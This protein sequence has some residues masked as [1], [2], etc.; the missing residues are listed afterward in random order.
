MS[1]ISNS[2]EKLKKNSNV[3]KILILLWL[4]VNGI[5]MF[6]LSFDRMTSLSVA[7]LFIMVFYTLI[8]AGKISYII[9]KKDLHK[10]FLISFTA[11]MIGFVIRF[12]LE[13][14]E[15]TFMHNLTLLNVISYLLIV[16]LLVFTG[17]YLEEKRRSTQE[18]Q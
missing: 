9:Y 11:N 8:S 6:P 2:D 10:I 14:G 1:E 15:T 7:L 4:I 5:A 17:S 13:Y 16:P 12:V 3:L 18:I